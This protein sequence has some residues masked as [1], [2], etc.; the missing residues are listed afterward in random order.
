MLVYIDCV[1]YM[2]HNL[3]TSFM[4]THQLRYPSEALGE[5]NIVLMRDSGEV[6]RIWDDKAE[7]IARCIAR[8][9]RGQLQ[10]VSHVADP[11]LNELILIHRLLG[12]EGPIFKWVD[13]ELSNYSSPA[14]SILLAERSCGGHSTFGH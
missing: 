8:I 3:E 11:H 12:R 10:P 4:T 5:P 1:A 9:D 13:V 7:L 2:D 6:V 14:I